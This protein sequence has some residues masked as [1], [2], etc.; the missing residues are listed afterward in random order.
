[1]YLVIDSMN[2]V[3]LPTHPGNWENKDF[4]GGGGVP[5]GEMACGVDL[6]TSII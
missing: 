4:D 1:M 6:G 5:A 3:A 2:R